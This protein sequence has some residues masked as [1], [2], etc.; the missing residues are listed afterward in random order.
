MSNDRA[1]VIANLKHIQECL[2]NV[3]FE[4][5]KYLVAKN[6]NSPPLGEADGTF[7]NKQWTAARDAINAIDS[8][9]WN[10]QTLLE[11]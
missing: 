9:I 11:E 10:F 7:N 2:N 3:S 1:E 8:F 5:A 6:Q 4:R